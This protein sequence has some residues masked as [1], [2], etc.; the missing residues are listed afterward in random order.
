MLLNLALMPAYQML[1]LAFG[2]FRKYL[3]RPWKVR[4]TP[5]C[6]ITPKRTL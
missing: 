2:D 1:T 6:T 3:V 4:T 5:D